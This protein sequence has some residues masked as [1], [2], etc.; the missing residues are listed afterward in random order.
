[1]P[2]ARVGLLQLTGTPYHDLARDLAADARL[3]ALGIPAALERAPQDPGGFNIEG[4]T[5]TLDGKAVL[6]GF[7]NP[8][9]QGRALLV[10]LENPL[11]V[12][13]G[14]PGSF[15]APILLELAGLGVRSLSSW[16]G[17]YLIAAGAFG[18]EGARSRL[19]RWR[20]PGHAPEPMAGAELHDLNPEGFFTPEMGDSIMVLSDD[21]ART[22]D[23][24]RCKDLKDDEQ[25]RFRGLWIQSR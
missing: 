18:E 5:A 23:G 22:I 7:R 14:Q 20:G 9:P 1:L 12:I 10:P 19:F 8:V 3:Q 13:N 2:G 25:K 15:G 4:M 21:G 16:R 17:R 11:A 24:E 6:L